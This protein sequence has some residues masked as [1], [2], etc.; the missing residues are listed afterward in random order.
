MRPTHQI[1]Y[2]IVEIV[3]KFLPTEL[4]S[5]LIELLSERDRALRLE[6]RARFEEINKSPLYRAGFSGSS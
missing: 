2:R 4:M 5:E 3:A 1:D 6:E